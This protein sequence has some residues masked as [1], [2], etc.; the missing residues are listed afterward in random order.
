MNILQTLE[1]ARSTNRVKRMSPEET[2]AFYTWLYH[3][4]EQLGYGGES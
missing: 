1:I 2:K 3:S 4:I